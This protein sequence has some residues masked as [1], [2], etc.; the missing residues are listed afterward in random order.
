MNEYIKRAYMRIGVV[1]LLVLAVALIV[2][3]VVRNSRG[4]SL[5]Y[6]AQHANPASI[7]TEIEDVVVGNGKEIVAG[8]KVS[9]DYV[10]LL[11]NGSAF[12]TSREDWAKEYGI[13][14]QGRTYS[15]Y[16]LTVGSGQVIR[17]W[18]EGLLGMK[19]GGVRRLAI[20]ASKAYG[21]DGNGTIPGNSMLI[22]EINLIKVE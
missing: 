20:P 15:P 10:G 11:T 2:F 4:A 1:S 13:F 17:G 3:G 18:D 8:A 16:E 7:E 6:F 22:F 12:D 19:E 9:V 14:T 21:K 5:T